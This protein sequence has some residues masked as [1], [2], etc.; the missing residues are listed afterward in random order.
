M[1]KVLKRISD[2]TLDELKQYCHKHDINFNSYRPYFFNWAIS[3]HEDDLI[4]FII[5]IGKNKIVTVNGTV[6]FGN[7]HHRVKPKTLSLLNAFDAMIT[8]DVQDYSIVLSPGGTY[9]VMTLHSKGHNIFKFKLDNDTN[10]ET[11]I[12]N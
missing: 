9:Y 5:S 4:Q 8:K 3:K 6:C 10:R 12:S 11:A 1:I 7:E 2:Y